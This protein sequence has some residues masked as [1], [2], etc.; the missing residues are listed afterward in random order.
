MES[1]TNS[2]Y[3]EFTFK[4]IEVIRL[5]KKGYSTKEIAEILN[6]SFFTIKKHRENI[7]NKALTKGKRQFRHFIFE[8]KIQD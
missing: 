2:S 1:N 8:F 4:E 6:K 3:C 7:S 5:L